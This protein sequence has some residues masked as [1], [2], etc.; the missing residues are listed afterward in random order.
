MSDSTKT[1]QEDILHGQINA[2]E[3]PKENS[4][5][6]EHEDLPNTP[7]KITKTQEGFFLRMGDYRITDIHKDKQSA[8]HELSKNKWLIIIRIIGAIIERYLSDKT[9]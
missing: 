4:T 5:L 2:E 3:T 9:K 1:T 8:T 6:V 7:F